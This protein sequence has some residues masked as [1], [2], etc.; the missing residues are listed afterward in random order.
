MSAGKRDRKVWAVVAGG[1]TGGHAVPAVAIGRA[2]V[3][4]GHPASSV[5]FVGSRRGIESRMA[6]AAGFEITLLPGR[7]IA[8]RLSWSNFGAVAGLVAAVVQATWLLA[9]LRPAV[10]ISV[11]GYASV[12]CSVAA[13]VLRI[14]LVVAEQNA[15]PGLANRLAGRFA[16]ACAVSFPETAMPRAVLTGNPV[17]PEI[18]AADRSPAGITAARR[19]LGL[20]EGHRVIA[21]AGGSLGARRIN[22]ATLG[23]ARMWEDRQGI[24]I[25]HVVGERDYQAVRDGAAG[26]A[27]TPGPGSGTGP[28]PSPALIYQLVGFE[29]RMD[30]LLTAADVAVQRA[31]ASTVSEVA[32]VGVPSLLVPLPGAPGDHQTLNAMRMVD[33]GAAVMV[34]D[35]E[36]SA[37]RLAEELEALLNDPVRLDSM[38]GAARSLAF[39][40]AAESVAALAEK[41]ARG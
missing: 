3:D 7:G 27:D 17:R 29:D 38:S 9:R 35:S 30:L 13:V 31:G 37:D 6:P 14:P 28:D 22:E 24:A 20:P 33:A 21:V 39:P 25:R 36:L 16:R 12:A 1:G 4:R 8:R 10:V 19:A 2:L 40:D 26:L 32:V 11:G 18:L 41:H 5:H 15:V 23:L 34:P